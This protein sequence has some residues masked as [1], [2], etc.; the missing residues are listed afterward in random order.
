[1]VKRGIMPKFGYWD[2]FGGFLED[3]EDLIKG[4]QREAKEELGVRLKAITYL[5]IYMDVYDFQYRVHTMNIIYQAQIASGRLQAMSD[6]SE[7]RWFSRNTIP[8]PRLAFPR[9]MKPAL[10]DWLKLQK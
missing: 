9:W 5:G 6:V 7:Y 3:G 10:R 8:W 4:L 1:M 2:V